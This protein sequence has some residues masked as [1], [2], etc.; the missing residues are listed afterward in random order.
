MVI[1]V[2]GLPGSGKTFFSQCL[3]EKIKAVHFNSD[4]I[5]KESGEWNQ[6]GDASKINVYEVMLEKMREAVQS[7]YAVVVDATFYK[8]ELR[9]KFLHASLQLH[10]PFRMIEVRAS[11][12]TIKQ[13]LSK[14]R[15]DSQ[16]DYSVYKKI[17]NEFEPV[18]EEHLVLF[19][20]KETIAEMTQKA[21]TYLVQE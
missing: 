1:L 10:Q 8:K 21:T 2:F 4:R 20:D 12:E 7:G 17:K 16:A 3:A 11:E 13:R 19:S 18:T 15:E 9:D 5:R 6:Y 14:P